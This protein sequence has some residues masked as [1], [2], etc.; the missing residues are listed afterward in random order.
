MQDTF[1]AGEKLVKWLIF[2]VDVPAISRIRGLYLGA[3]IDV[4]NA[5]Y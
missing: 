2:M 4:K 5:A 3:Q 1:I